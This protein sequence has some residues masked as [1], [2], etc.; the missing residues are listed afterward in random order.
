MN[1]EFEAAY[2]CII[3]HH[4]S[5]AYDR[6]KKLYY[7]ERDNSHYFTACI[8]S[9]LL[10]ENIDILFEF[11]EQESIH[12][13][14]SELIEI[15]LNGINFY[16]SSITPFASSKKTSDIFNIIISCF[17]T[18]R[19]TK[20]NEL[21]YLFL[22]TARILKPNDYYLLKYSSEESFKNGS[23]EKGC[24]LLVKAAK[25]WSMKD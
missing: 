5:E 6:F 1:S 14:H 21:S 23:I 15:I 16:K 4:Y 7:G 12:K 3:M 11:I 18:I 17:R 25:A 24:S 9:L 8:I 10:K 22:R 19:Q 2:N 13:K 20:F